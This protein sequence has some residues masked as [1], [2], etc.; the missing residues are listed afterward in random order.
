M[1]RHNIHLLMG[2]NITHSVRHSASKELG[3][4]IESARALAYVANNNFCN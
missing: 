2:K 3:P 4:L 1:L